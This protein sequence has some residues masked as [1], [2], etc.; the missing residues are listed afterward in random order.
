MFGFGSNKEKKEIKREEND[1]KAIVTEDLLGAR[2]WQTS[3][4]GYLTGLSSVSRVAGAF[5]GNVSQ[6][7]GRLALVFS[8]L[9]KTDDLEALPE[10]DAASYDGRERFKA[11]MALH[12]RKESD[13]I[14]ARGMTWRQT[15]LY[16]A[17]ALIS[18]IYLVWDLYVRTTMPLTVLGLHVAPIPIFSAFALKAAYSNWMFRIE[19]LEPMRK[20]LKSGDW[21]PRT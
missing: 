17:I 10:V 6:S 13:L 8:L 16:G 18:V 14:R 21:L 3:K 2:D 5:I 19:S 7:F 1:L 12:R 15:Y 11:A 20:F 4:V 9:T